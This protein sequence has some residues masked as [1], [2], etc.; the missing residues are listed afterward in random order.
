MNKYKVVFVKNGATRSTIV[1][2]A[3]SY[4]AY[5]DWFNY[6]DMDW[7]A[8]KLNGLLVHS[9]DMIQVYRVGSKTATTVAENAAAPA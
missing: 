3:M 9:P 1:D 4:E 8:Y 5:Q 6:K 2:S 7:Q